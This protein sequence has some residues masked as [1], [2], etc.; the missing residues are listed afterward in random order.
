[1]SAVKDGCT[2]LNLVIQRGKPAVA[3]WLLLWTKQLNLNVNL[4]DSK[5]DA[6]LHSCVLLAKELHEQ[7]SQQQQEVQSTIITSGGLNANYR[8]GELAAAVAA[9]C[10]ILSYVW[11]VCVICLRLLV[12]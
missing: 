3:R 10:V 2:I 9:V 1:M 12:L 7:E 5:H 11:W 6:P 4:P 8:D